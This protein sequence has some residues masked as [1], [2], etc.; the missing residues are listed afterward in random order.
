VESWSNRHKVIDLSKHNYI[1]KYY[2]TIIN[3]S[4]KPEEPNGTKCF[5]EYTHEIA[6]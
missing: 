1:D 5:D 2:E 3:P 4:T 6:Y